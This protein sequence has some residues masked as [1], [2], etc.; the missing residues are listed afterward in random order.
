[1][2]VHHATASPADLRRYAS[3]HGSRVPGAIEE[4]ILRAER[5]LRHP[6]ATVLRP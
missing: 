6:L 2:A 3:T 1:V 5:R 4:Q